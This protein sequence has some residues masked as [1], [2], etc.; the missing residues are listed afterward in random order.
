VSR[1]EQSSQGALKSGTPIRQDLW[2]VPASVAAPLL[3]LDA[4]AQRQGEWDEQD[5]RD[6]LN[7][8]LEAPL[9]F[10]QEQ[11]SDVE[12]AALEEVGAGCARDTTNCPVYR[13]ADVLLSE[14][15]PLE[16]LKL[17]KDYAKGGDRQGADAGL[18]EEV[19][20]VLYYAAIFVALSRGGH[21]I[22]SLDDRTLL[23]GG[24]WVV[25]QPWVEHPVR[26]I[27]VN[28]LACLSGAPEPASAPV[29]ASEL[30]DDEPRQRRIGATER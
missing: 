19:A 1:V 23:R 2:R 21:R 18:P 20:T 26:Q 5:L 22:S 3:R 15:P 13:F 27:V 11:L 8:Q 12:R 4:E 16:L 25:A 10:D 28:G 17:V 29:R 9:L 30:S 6:I 7:H 24:R 14:T